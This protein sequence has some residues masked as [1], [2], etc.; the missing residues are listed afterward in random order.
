MVEK[1]GLKELERRVALLLPQSFTNI[2][3]LQWTPKSDGVSATLDLEV[4]HSDSVLVFLDYKGSALVTM[5]GEAF[6]SLDGY[7]KSVSIGQGKHAILAEFTPYLAFGEK[8]AMSFGT[9]ILAVRN[10]S[11]YKFWIYC[12][13][14]LDLAKQS[15]DREVSSDLFDLLS[16]SLEAAFFES[17]TQEQIQL[18]TYLHDK[19]PRELVNTIPKRTPAAEQL[20]YREH[21]TVAKWHDALSIL[22]NGLQL[23]VK[24][25]GKRGEILGIAHGHIDTAWLWPFSETEKKVARTFSVVATLLD[26]VPDFHYIQSMA[27]YYDWMKKDQPALYERIKRY[28]REGR[29]ELGAGWV[30]NDANMPCGESFA[31]QLLYSQQFYQKEF[32]RSANVHWLPDSFGFAASIPQIAKL[33]GISLFATHKLFWN[34]TNTFPYALFNWVGIDGTSLP[35]I[36]FGQGRDGYNST[37]AIE[38][39]I[40]QWTNWA[41]KDIDLPML[42]AFGYG[43][44]GGGPTEEMFLR[45]EAVDKL[46]ILPNVRLTSPLGHG[47]SFLEKNYSDLI[48]GKIGKNAWRGELYVETHRG[49]QTS[50]IKMKYLNRRAEFALRE[51]EIWSTILWSMNKASNSSSQGREGIQKLWKILLKHQ[52]HDVLPGSSINEV[53]ALAYK[54]LEE[55]LAGAERVAIDSMKHLCEVSSSS[56]GKEIV[57]F[58]SLPWRRADEYVVFPTEIQSGQMVDA[59]YL[60][61]V[62][63]P[64]VGFAFQAEA[65]RAV[66]PSNSVSFQEGST[67]CTIENQFLKVKLDK[68]DGSIASI[69]DKEAEREVLKAKSNQFVFYENSPGWADAW[70]IEK[71]YRNTSFPVSRW[72]S[73]EVLEKGPLRARVMIK[74][75]FRHSAIEQELIMHAGSRRID[76]KTTTNLQDRELL[77]KV[78]FHF[79]INADSAVFEIPFGNI[80]RKTTSNTSWEKAKF[81]VPMLNWV[82]ISEADYG[83]AMLNDGRYGIA[84]EGTSL[85]LSV[86]K[87]PMYPD[88]ATDSEAN[89]FVFSI[90]PHRSG[91][92]EAEIPQRALELNVPIRSVAGGNFKDAEFSKAPHGGSPGK[93][94]V[95]IDSSNLMLETLKVSEDQSGIV[96]RLYEMHNKRG[97]ASLVIWNAAKQAIA[98]DLLERDSRS[99]QLQ[100]SDQKVEIPYRNYQILTAKITL[101]KG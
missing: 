73:C 67:F 42:F 23:L 39:V 75:K 66:S 78:W 44:G 96:C 29:W 12:S 24:K 25:Y 97:T 30:E 65:I 31:R 61:R 60:T 81:E 47:E 93:S 15:K 57:L 40:E 3:F 38:E 10:P 41:D 91:W 59:G 82:D 76:F 48:S 86:A 54:E 74:R 50:H 2:R 62:D 34:D 4:N 37:F 13:T 101:T 64:S 63:V 51:A 6:W 22:E 99:K 53:Y 8:T 46:P 85:G 68:N 35:S 36:Y 55:V 43:D 72:E 88:F 28:V 80:E 32:G 69:F 52:F 26:R 7:H 21:A 33:G 87:T 79:D 92:R 95:T 18:A 89:T 83:V 27:L 19:F 100:L 58:N 14:V 17:V 90:Y 9:P 1:R 94:F 56:D 20:G 11:A 98:T 77:L 45:A 84:V 5:D 49:V 70:D 71:G 16:D